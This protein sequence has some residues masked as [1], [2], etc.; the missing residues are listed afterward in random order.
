MKLVQV[1][2]AALLIAA[3]QLL[4]AVGQGNPTAASAAI[5]ALILAFLPSVLASQK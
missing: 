1:S 3:G 4:V 5:T 2:Y